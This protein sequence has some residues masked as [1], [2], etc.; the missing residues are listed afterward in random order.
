V[1]SSRRS[2]AA[3]QA[4][5]VLDPRRPFI[6]DGGPLDTP[7]RAPD[8]VLCTRLPTREQFAALVSL[9]E[10]LVF[11]TGAQLPYLRSL[12]AP[13]TPVQLPS[14]ADRARDRTEALR[15]RVARLLTEGNV[16]AELARLDPLF[17][18]FDPAEVAAA[19][20]AIS[21]QPSAASPTPDT[22]APGWTKVFVNVGKKDRAGAKDFVGAL[23]REVGIGKEAVG[24]ID[25]RE[26]FSVVE[27]A[28]GVAEK[29]VRGLT[30]VVIKGRRA[31]ARL[32]RQAEPR[33]R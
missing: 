2:A 21:H 32:D 31:L 5:E 33:S 26:T 6:W 23:I 19:L 14:T 10:P 1:A 11:I 27:V 29:V 25:V 17:E 22:P 4:L 3:R 18:R 8:A 24:R 16:D 12:A 13:L 30:G 7:P 28:S 20:L 15:E 9:G